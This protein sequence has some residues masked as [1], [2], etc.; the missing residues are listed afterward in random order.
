MKSRRSN[1]PRSSQA[2]SSTS[3]T[4]IGPVSLDWKINVTAL[5]AFV[6]SLS[7]LTL[8]A[9]GYWRGSVVSLHR[10]EKVLINS[11]GNAVRFGSRMVY[12][13][14]GGSGYNALILRESVTLRIGKHEYRQWAEERGTFGVDAG[15]PVLKDAEDAAPFMVPAMQ[16]VSHESY[17]AARERGTGADRWSD[18]LTREQLVQLL[19]TETIPGALKFTFEARSREISGFDAGE[20]ETLSTTCTITLDEGLIRRLANEGWSSRSC[21]VAGG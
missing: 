1:G 2:E 19:E 9:M 20:E 6:I 11:D 7:A 8:Q 3:E 4:K 21:Q 15:V 17:F 12:T 10:A 14:D 16:L 5:V 18:R 13:N